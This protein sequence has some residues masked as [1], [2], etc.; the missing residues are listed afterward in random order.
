MKKQ[1]TESVSYCL[2]IALYRTPQ[3]WSSFTSKVKSLPK[4]NLFKPKK[5]KTFWKCTECPCKL[6]KTY[7]KNMGYVSSK[8]IKTFN[9][10]SL[11]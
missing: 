9:P 7:L 8:S 2:E 11:K 1:K 3:I 6:S 4:I 5:K 10:L